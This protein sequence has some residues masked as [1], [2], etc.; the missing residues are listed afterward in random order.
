MKSN[1]DR[2]MMVARAAATKAKWPTLDDVPPVDLPAGE[3]KAAGPGAKNEKQWVNGDTRLAEVEAMN[4]W[5]YAE[6]LHKVCAN[7][8]LVGKAIH[9]TIGPVLVCAVRPFNLDEARA[10]PAKE[11]WPTVD[12]AKVYLAAKGYAD[13]SFGKWRLPSP[14]HIPT[15]KQ[16]KCLAVL[17][18]TT[19]D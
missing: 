8:D 12:D 1:L 7:G 18:A 2:D 11:P 17:G 10:M 6:A 15:E 19:I 9:P 4:G 5:G 16:A 13:M 14:G 3:F